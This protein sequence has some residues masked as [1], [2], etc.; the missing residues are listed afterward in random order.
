MEQVIS[1]KKASYGFVR[2]ALPMTTK[3]TMLSW[4]KKSG[5]GKAEFFRV[6]LMMGVIQLSDQVHAKSSGE[7][8]QEN[9]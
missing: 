7:G 1:T 4:C 3:E 6:S 2:V 9:G 5:M 8:Y